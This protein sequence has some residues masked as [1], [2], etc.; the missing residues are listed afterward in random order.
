MY[1]WPSTVPTPESEESPK[2]PWYRPRWWWSIPAAIIVIGAVTGALVIGARSPAKSPANARSVAKRSSAGSTGNTGSGAVGTG[3][4]ATGSGYVVFIQWTTSGDSLSGTAQ[5][6]TLNGSPPNSSV[7]TQT[8]S[9]SGTFTGS[10]I[11][12]RFNDGAEVF[13]TLSGG[14]FTV[15]FPQSDGAL[16][17]ITFTTATAKQFN[18]A[19]S[20]LQGKTGSA[21]QSAAAAQAIAKQR[22]TI[23]TEARAVA[24]DISGIGSDQTQLSNDLGGFS[25]D[26]ATMKSDL[27]TVASQEQA[28]ITE[29]QNGTDP[30]QVCDD[31]NTD[32]DDANTV[33]DDGNS[34]SDTANSIETDI[35]T[36]RGDVT[37]LNSDFSGLQSAQAQQPSYSDGAPTS[38]AVASAVASAQAAIAAALNEANGAIG[39][40]N[41]YE[42]QAT[43]DATAAAQAGNCSGPA[44]QYTQPTIT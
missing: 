29:S 25:S 17:P 5:E 23:D 1:T 37:T 32:G 11:A 26:L 21:N 30:N 18:Q 27:A 14:S 3:Y 34:V 6:T 7:N 22:S 24:E 33:G 20:R 38:K 13:G 44:T 35:S 19:L 40:A 12:L 42:Q 43:A 10:T 28:V 16:A 39:Q 9:L 41:S 36:L 31:S 8:I 15:N 2:R 4:L